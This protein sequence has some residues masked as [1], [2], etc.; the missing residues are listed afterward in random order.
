MSVVPASDWRGIDPVHA[1]MAGLRA[2]ESGVSVLRSTRFGLSLVVDPHG[3]VRAWRSSFEP[4]SGV[5]YAALSTARI[6][7]IYALCG[8]GPLWAAAAILAL[9]AVLAWRRGHQRAMRT[10][11]P[12]PDPPTGEEAGPTLQ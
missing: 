8:D 6:S 9:G 1:Q 11:W 7:T 2:I 4:G 10:W 12:A 5:M 3:R